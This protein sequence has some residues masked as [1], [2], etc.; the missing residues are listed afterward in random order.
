MKK[1][2]SVWVGGAEVND[3]YLNLE[4]AESLK[5]VYLN[6]GYEDIYIEEVT[7]E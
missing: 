5:K 6:D 2:Y 3:Y 7:N 1:K 4:Q